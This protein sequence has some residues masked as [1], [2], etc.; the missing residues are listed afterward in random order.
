MVVTVKHQIVIKIVVAYL[1]YIYC[2]CVGT[3]YLSVVGLLLQPSIL[4]AIAKYSLLVF[5]ILLVARTPN[6]HTAGG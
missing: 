1:H 2:C 3:K 5:K 4:V 6:T